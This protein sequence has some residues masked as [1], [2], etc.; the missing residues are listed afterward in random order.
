MTSRDHL[1]VQRRSE[2]W[3]SG[4]SLSKDVQIQSGGPMKHGDIN[5][6]LRA[7]GRAASP[8]AYCP[9]EHLNRTND[10][11]IRQAIRTGGF[12]HSGADQ[13]GIAASDMPAETRTGGAS[14][15]VVFENRHSRVEKEKLIVPAASRALI[16]AD[17]TTRRVGGCRRSN[18]I[19]VQGITQLVRRRISFTPSI[20]GKEIVSALSGRISSRPIR[21]KTSCVCTARIL[22]LADFAWLRPCTRGRN[23]VP[24]VVAAEYQIYCTGTRS[25]DFGPLAAKFEIAERVAVPPCGVYPGYG[26][27]LLV[28]VYV[29][30][31]SGIT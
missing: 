7:L 25:E 14:V 31:Q 9:V 16:Y 23:R 27:A 3:A 19:L 15:Y 1:S 30:S 10:G 13:P 12:T 2:Q 8:T 6:I 29:K 26:A 24:H 28:R 22:V 20:F 4:G 11:R 21:T 18:N 17:S 5:I